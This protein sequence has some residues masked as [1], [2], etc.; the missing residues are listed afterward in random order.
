[1]S[2]LCLSATHSVG[3]DLH[4]VDTIFVPGAKSGQPEIY[5]DRT[6]LDWLRKAAEHV[7][8]IAAVGSGA[9]VLAEAGLLQG[10]C[11]TTH[12]RDTELLKRA[13]SEISVVKDVLFTRD[14]PIYTS[15]GVAGG[16]DQALAMVEEDYGRAISLKV[17]RRLVVV[18]RR[19]GDQ[20]QLSSLLALQAKSIRFGDLIDRIY[21]SLRQDLS[22][23]RL[24]EMA[25]MSPRN[26]TRVFHAE[27]G[28]APAQFVRAVRVEV[29]RRLI[30][31]GA[32]RLGSVARECGFASEEQMRRAFKAVLRTQPRN[33]L[34]REWRM[35]NGE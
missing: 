15:A 10:R 23:P 4:G 22:V 27:L 3:D 33:L 24:A 8:R 9:F 1:M 35:A 12:W 25:A 19:P 11:A 16:I 17:A 21:R 6:M 20:A 2:G 29:A 5:R 18:Y 7:R 31:E 30:S 26:F 14:G 28:L 34:N 13:Y 32:E